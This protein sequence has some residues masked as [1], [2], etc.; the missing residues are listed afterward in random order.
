MLDAQEQ[1]LLEGLGQMRTRRLVTAITGR[2][3]GRGVLDRIIECCE[4]LPLALRIAASRLASRTGLTAHRL[5]D[6]LADQRSRLDELDIDGLAVRTSMRV[7][8]DALRD[9]QDAADQLAASL[10]PWLVVVPV[11]TFTAE[12]G[13]DVAGLADV[14][15]VR[16]AMGRLVNLHLVHEAGAQRYGLHDLIRLFAIEEKVSVLSGDEQECGAGRAFDHYLAISERICEI[17]TPGRRSRAQAEPL[18]GALAFGP[19]TADGAS[20]WLDAEITNIIAA[21]EFALTL[22]GEQAMFGFHVTHML[23]WLLG[24]RAVWL[25]EL[26]LARLADKAAA[27]NGHPPQRIDALAMRGQAELHLGRLAEADEHLLTAERLSEEHGELKRLMSILG[28]RACVAVSEGR[29]ELA[30]QRLKRSLA[31]TREEGWTRTRRSSCSTW[32]AR[33]PRSTSGARPIRRLRPAWR[34]AAGSGTSR[35]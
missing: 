20:G 27:A 24:K 1:V 2:P 8:L 4:R 29:P 34:S 18:A 28:D 12:F 13:A 6:R 21:A 23:H 35:V 10:L 14:D 31:I 33:L 16:R 22:P 32:P 19:D 30:M 11:P 9:S 25:Q 26:A 7:S 15:A 17:L 3:P 5:A